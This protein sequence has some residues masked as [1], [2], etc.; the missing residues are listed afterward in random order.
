MGL[1]QGK[2]TKPIL[3][4][5]LTFFVWSNFSFVQ[6][7]NSDDITFEDH[8]YKG[9]LIASSNGF[10]LFYRQTFPAGNGFS[11][12][13]DISLTSVRNVKEKSVLNQ[14]VVGNTSPYIFGKVNRLYALRPMIGLQ[15]TLAERISKNSVGINAFAAMGPT[16]GFLK[17]IYVDVLTVDPNVPSSYVTVSRRYEPF[18]MDPSMINGYSSF[19]KGIKY[20]KL[21]AGLSL[22]SG[23]E[24]NWGTYTSVFRSIEIG[25]LV[26]YFPGRPNV[27]YGIKNKVLYSSFYISFALGELY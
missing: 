9:G 14:R 4:F 13:I 8:S 25:F 27:L 10:G 26:D 15:K 20:S 23:V 6:A 18:S 19:D 16:L 1:I 5:L 12:L 3:S 2:N 22:K 17:P 11:K 7:Q 24:F 21:M